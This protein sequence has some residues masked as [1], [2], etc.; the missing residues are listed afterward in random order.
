[1]ASCDVPAVAATAPPIC[2]SLYSSS[3]L[4]LS[5]TLPISTTSSPAS[6]TMMQACTNISAARAANNGVK[7]SK[8]PK[9]EL[10]RL[11]TELIL[12]DNCAPDAV[13]STAIACVRQLQC[14]DAKLL[15]CAPV[16]SA[17][18]LGLGLGLHYPPPPPGP[19]ASQNGRQQPPFNLYPTV[20]L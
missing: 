5:S 13:L 7:S 16:L 15:V 1:M 14:D 11:R 20:I 9:A 10:S 3:P 8:I 12:P 2:A 4:L 6:H 18:G 17:M 19:L